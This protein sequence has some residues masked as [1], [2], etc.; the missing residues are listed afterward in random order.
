MNQ[1]HLNAVR[2]TPNA[3]VHLFEDDGIFPNNAKLP[4]VLYQGAMKL[5]KREPALTIEET[6]RTHAWVSSWR[7]GIFPYHHYHS[8]A[9]EVLGVSCGSAQ[10]RLGGDHN[11][12]TFVVQAGD[13]IVIPAGVA[14]KSLGSTFDFQVIG[15]YPTGQNYDMNY[16]ELGE[17]PQA[18][19][20]IAQVPLPKLDPV[21]GKGGLLAGHW[22]L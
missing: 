21:Y 3:V 20:N 14:H 11:G 17:R 13:V 16:G 18:D 15:A 19:Q 2:Q 6:F 4:L 5:P 8:T 10:V 9:H 12:Q 7:N 1:Q 22:H